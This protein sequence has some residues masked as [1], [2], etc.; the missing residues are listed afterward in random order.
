MSDAYCTGSSLMPQKRNPDC[1]ELL[2][3]AAGGALGRVVSIMATLK[4]LPMTYNKD[5]QDDKR[6]LFAAI[7][8]AS[9]IVQLSTGLIATMS[10]DVAAM[11]ADLAPEMLATDLA[12]HLVRLGVP[13]RE[14][15][16]IIGSVVKL[17]DDNKT[18][19]DKLSLADLRSIDERFADNVETVFDFD[20]SVESRNSTGGT[21]KRAVQQ[22]IE[23]ML[24]QCK[25]K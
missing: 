8:D 4:S 25:K 9:D 3:G 10:V 17:A 12:D 11:R 20:T 21:S 2:R 19:I 18:T 23:N 15:H 1:A 24:V 5:L 13:F 6:L 7:D 16:H 22:Q 14:A